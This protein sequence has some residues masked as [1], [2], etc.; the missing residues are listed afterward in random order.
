MKINSNVSM[1]LSFI[2]ITA[3]LIFTLLQLF[4]GASTY[5]LV[6]MAI[7]SALSIFPLAFRTI[8]TSDILWVVFTTYNSTAA[9][10]I[11]TFLGQP[12]DQNLV[13][14]SISASYLLLGILSGFL[15]YL[16][17]RTF[18]H[19]KSAPLQLT[20]LTTS[21][22]I[23]KD[24][25]I[26][27][28]LIGMLAQIAHNILRPRA[29]SGQITDGFGGF[30][31][32]SILIILGVSFQAYLWRTRP[33]EPKHAVLL[34]FMF[35]SV[36][37]LALLSNIKKPAVDSLLVILLSIVLI[38]GR[39]V[40]FATYL[41]LTC[42]CIA[43]TMVVAPLIQVMRPQLRSYA[44]LE[45]YQVAT[46]TL[47]DSHYNL[48]VLWDKSANVAKG[49]EYSYGKNQSYLFPSTVNADRFCLLMPIDQV[50]RSLPARGTLGFSSL[51][52][53]PEAYIPGFLIHKTGIASPD[54]IAWHY[55]VR[56]NGSI[57]RPVIGLIASSAAFGDIYAVI[58]FP[59]VIIFIVFG[60]MELLSGPAGSSPWSIFILGINLQKVG[61]KE[62][63]AMINYGSREIPVM[64]IVGLC[65]YFYGKHIRRHNRR[66]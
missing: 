44:P 36:V 23:L 2:W 55:G 18:I 21:P 40:R 34:A 24:L 9:L 20:Q 47:N 58:F 62:V 49:Y 64:F 13:Q 50:V 6:V 51:A 26:I 15:G 33:N 22:L 16:L 17:A 57:A 39:P 8:T 12:I 52:D 3:L 48:Y 19:S 28:F 59:G 53:V 11:K 31:T 1:I 35:I 65:I 4:Y 42:L 37:T 27:I 38:K 30:G 10:V 61:E 41:S 54:I 63:S 25:S 29:E 45:I 32:L 7:T 56:A 46:N 5:V 60:I 66:D 43:L 14:P